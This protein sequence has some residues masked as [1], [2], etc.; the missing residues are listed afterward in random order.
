[1]AEPLRL[2]ACRAGEARRRGSTTCS[3]R[4]G[5]PAETA[6]ALF[7]HEFSGGQRQRLCIARALAT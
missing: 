4:S 5:L 1:V 7:P 2:Q 6:G 3:P